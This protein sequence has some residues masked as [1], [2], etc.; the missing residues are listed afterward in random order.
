MLDWLLEWDRK[1]LIYLNNLGSEPYDL[2]WTTVT[3]YPPWIPLFLLFIFL[4]FRFYSWKQA[5]GML[6]TLGIMV[7]FVHT[8]TDLTKL[9]VERPR[10]SQLEELKVL[11]RILKNP[12]SYSFFSAHAAVSFSITTFMVIFLK[13]KIK[14]VYL[15]YIWPLLFVMSRIYLGVHFPLDLAIGAVVGAIS[16]WIFSKIYKN[17]TLP[18]LGSTHP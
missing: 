10:P 5:F 6:V 15:F 16:A 18:Y 8:V 12:S 7:I 9:T 17:I 3:K 1:T 14:W 11:V 2:F 4:L 13:H